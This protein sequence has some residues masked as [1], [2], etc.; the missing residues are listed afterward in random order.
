MHTNTTIHKHTLAQY[1]HVV[2]WGITF[3]MDFWL[4]MPSLCVFLWLTTI[5][6]V[7]LRMDGYATHTHV[8]QSENFTKFRLK[9]IDVN[10]MPY[11]MPSFILAKVLQT[12]PRWWLNDPILQ[13]WCTVSPTRTIHT[14]TNTQTCGKISFKYLENCTISHAQ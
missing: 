9:L 6:F 10:I 12:K 11:Y 5:Y 8:S 7:G 14:H 1:E 4:L 13:I 2:L 3:P